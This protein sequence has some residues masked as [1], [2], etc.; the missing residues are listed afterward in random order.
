MTISEMLLP[1]YDQEMAVARKLLERVP[2]EKGD[3]KPHQKSMPLGRL[4]GHVAELPTWAGRIVTTEMIDIGKMVSGQHQ[5]YIPTS[6]QELLQKFDQSVLEARQSIAGASDAHLSQEWTLQ[7]NGQTVASGTR[8][9]MIRFMSMNHLVH[10][11]AQLSVYLRLNDIPL[12]A[13]YGPS[14]DE[15]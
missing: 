3:W 13:M 15:R 5:P 7:F 9:Q 4:T 10:H 6:Q 11:R 1:E 2:V 8:L 12:P 14:A